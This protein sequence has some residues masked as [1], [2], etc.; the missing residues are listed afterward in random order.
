MHIVI[1]GG[2]RG[3]GA[4]AVRQFAARGD[5]VTFLYR[6]HEQAAAATAAA[7][8]AAAIRADVSDGEAVKAA[9]SQ[10]GPVD[11][12]VNCA[13]IAHQGL[14][15]QIT[16]EHW[17]TIETTSFL[18]RPIKIRLFTRRAS[19]DGS[20]LLSNFRY[21]RQKD[22]YKRQIQRSRCRIFQYSHRLNIRRINIT[23][24]AIV[25]SSVH[26]I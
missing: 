5:A 14:I 15:S 6:A 1:T 23:Y 2:S 19:N 13:G 17:G 10:I 11:V 22:V 16:P 9:F 26:Y 4:A 8:G 3:I 18:Y 24:A 25:Y 20:Q 7:T 21:D 12:L